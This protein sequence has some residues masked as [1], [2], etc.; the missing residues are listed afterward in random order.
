MF[1]NVWN[2]KSRA[3]IDITNRT[4]NQCL[5]LSANA[6]YKSINTKHP[7]FVL[8]PQLR[9]RFY[10]ELCCILFSVWALWMCTDAE[11]FIYFDFPDMKLDLL[12]IIKV[13]S[14][15]LHDI[16]NLSH[17]HPRWLNWRQKLIVHSAVFSK[18]CLFFKNCFLKLPCLVS[19][20]YQHINCINHFD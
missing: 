11:T 7:D 12:T 3:V 4:I 9:W 15:P 13:V 20:A 8:T 16:L 2:R 14:A 18:L 19:N 17:P 1:T 5:Y 6:H 10:I